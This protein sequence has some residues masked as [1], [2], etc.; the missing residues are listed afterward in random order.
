MVSVWNRG[1]NSFTIEPGER[2]AQMVFVPVV[3]A[4]FNPGGRLRRYRPWRRR[5]RPFR[6]QITARQTRISQRHNA[7]TNR[8]RQFAGRCVVA[9]LTSA[10]FQGYFC[11]MAENKPRKGIVAKKYFNL[12]L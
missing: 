6:A 7:I 10:Y 5:L 3:Q 9:S 12:W 2:I 11:N 4:E 8:K 1:Q